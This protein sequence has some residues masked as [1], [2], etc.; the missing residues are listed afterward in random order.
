MIGDNIRKYR[1]AN[2]LSQ[3]ELA[4]KLNVT[5]QSISLWENGQTQPSLE[6]IVALA[7]MFGVSTDDL[8]AD[9][10]DP[11]PENNQTPT[12]SAK[13]KKKKT[14]LI[15]SLI[16]VILAA[17]TVF[18]LYALPNMI[19]NV[20]KSISDTIDSFNAN[21]K[22]A[23]SSKKTSSTKKTTVKKIIVGN[24]NTTSNT[25][26]SAVQ[27]HDMYGA[28]KQFI[29][30]NG[31]TSGSSC[32]FNKTAPTYGGDQGDNFSVSY[33]ASSDE[34]TVCISNNSV[35]SDDRFCLNT[36]LY[37]PKTNNG[38][39]K[40]VSSYNLK[41]TGESVY[42]ATGV[43]T[44]SQFNRNSP[45]PCSHF[46]G[47]AERQTSFLEMCRD[48]MCSLLTCMD[49]FL[50]KEKIGYSLCDFGFADF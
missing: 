5:R 4:E 27:A 41:S 17:V 44:A 19:S 34:V 29:L 22:K 3:D 47:P 40:Y 45:L 38:I 37:I 21:N 8:L 23:T 11:K 43:I 9:S 12:G 26:S 14:A 42:E 30:K 24:S 1:K 13:P 15:L 46:Y 20:S 2:N 6:Y 39:Y 36:Y 25:T 18:G 16:A 49:S 10:T 48:S 32:I 7:K 50:A 28:L 31:Q 33:W 35:G